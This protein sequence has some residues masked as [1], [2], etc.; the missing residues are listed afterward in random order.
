MFYNQQSDR[1]R[2]TP[3]DR[4]LTVK[5]LLSW[6]CIITLPNQLYVGHGSRINCCSGKV[7]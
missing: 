3:T 7:N 1:L 6:S 4:Y 5:K 2:M